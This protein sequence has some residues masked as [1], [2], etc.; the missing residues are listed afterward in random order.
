M[1]QLEQNFKPYK[2]FETYL[3]SEN[4]RLLHIDLDFDETA[5]PKGGER[6]ERLIE[7]REQK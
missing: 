1:D 2:N 4:F 7:E 3:S 6:L 5:N